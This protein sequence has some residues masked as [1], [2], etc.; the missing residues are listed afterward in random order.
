LKIFLFNEGLGGNN[1][2]NLDRI[3]E[4]RTLYLW[5]RASLSHLFSLAHL[6]K[7]QHIEDFTSYNLTLLMPSP[8]RKA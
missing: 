8:E 3:I 2:L 1:H 6:E 5:A 7:H 4:A